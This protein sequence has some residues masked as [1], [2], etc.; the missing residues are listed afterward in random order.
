MIPKE[1]KVNLTEV[2]PNISP[3]PMEATRIL[4][5]ENIG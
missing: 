4:F 2:Y 3:W 1:R 5:K